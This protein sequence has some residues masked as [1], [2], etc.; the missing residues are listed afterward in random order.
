MS[1]SSQSLHLLLKCNDT[2]PECAISSQVNLSEQIA[3][4]VTVYFKSPLSND[5]KKIVHLIFY[6]GGINTKV[7]IHMYVN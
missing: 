4:E 1:K 5:V 7:S 6:T 2:E 3:T